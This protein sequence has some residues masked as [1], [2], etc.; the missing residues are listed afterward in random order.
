MMSDYEFSEAQGDLYDEIATALQES[1][2]SYAEA[3]QVLGAILLAM[4][5]AEP[6]PLQ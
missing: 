1:S 3:V 5:I 6:M 4:Q 2:T